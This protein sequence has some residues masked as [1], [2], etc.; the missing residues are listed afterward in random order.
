ML[1][2]VRNA[3]S[4]P[5]KFNVTLWRPACVEPLTETNQ[6]ASSVPPWHLGPSLNCKFSWHKLRERAAVPELSI[7][8]E[9]VPN[10]AR[11]GLAED[12]VFELLSLAIQPDQ[13]FAP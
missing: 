6:S 11:E 8:L 7:P 9:E 10:F 3:S 4:L 5:S 2:L 13:C 1:K 12:H